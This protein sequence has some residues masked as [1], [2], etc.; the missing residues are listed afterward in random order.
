MVTCTDT[1]TCTRASSVVA[2]SSRLYLKGIRLPDAD[3]Q[4][5]KRLF[6]ESVRDLFCNYGQVEE[7]FV[8][9]RCA[10]YA[11]VAMATTSDAQQV[12]WN[13]VTPNTLFDSIHP[14]AQVPNNPNDKR[15][16]KKQ[17]RHVHDI[18]NLQ[19]LA[20]NAN[21]VLQCNKSHVERVE[22]VLLSSSNLSLTI[23]GSTTYKIVALVFCSCPEPQAVTLWLESIWYIRPIIQRSFIFEPSDHVT[24][25]V[26]CQCVDVPDNSV[27]LHALV[28][29]SNQPIRLNTY[30]PKLQSHFAPALKDT[31]IQWNPHS[32]TYV[33]NVLQLVPPTWQQKG[34]YWVGT[35][36][37]QHVPIMMASSTVLPKNLSSD[38]CSRAYYKLQEALERYRYAETL[39]FPPMA[40][41]IDVGASPG[42]W[43]QFLL[44][45]CHCTCLYSIDPGSI[46]SRVWALTETTIPKPVIIHVAKK[47]QDGLPE[48]A[49]V[50][51]REPVHWYVSDMCV[52]TMSEQIDALLLAVELGL[53]QT[54]TF[55][56]LTIKCTRGH[57]K[58]TFDHLVQQQVQRVASHLEQLQILHL[59]A[60]RSS[61]RTVMGY[62]KEKKE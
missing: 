21:L 22:E 7:I 34:L 30:P 16:A 36:K 52:K 9:D 35:S 39:C 28:D 45:H 50:R 27:L 51:H 8:R 18:D 54:S 11:F 60:N 43:T 62:W 10:D 44:E 24:S 20:K 61:E 48:I 32:P 29:L 47:Y 56:I 23:H 38:S 5:R 15:S 55:V 19:K 59:F 1:S 3:K 42:G 46:D 58:A 17:Q 4:D 13:T 40:S 12:L 14:A 33:L 57:S 31:P 53:V 49:T 25:P 6:Q 41:A 26:L 2:T 37:Y